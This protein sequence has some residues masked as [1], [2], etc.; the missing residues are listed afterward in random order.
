MVKSEFDYYFKSPGPSGGM[1]YD[2]KSIIRT[3]V[4]AYQFN[5]LSKGKM[6]L[7]LVGNDIIIRT[8][9]DS[10]FQ[11]NTNGAFQN[12]MVRSTV[13]RDDLLSKGYK[14]T[15][16]IPDMAFLFK[17]EEI[18]EIKNTV[19]LSFR[20]LKN[21]KYTD[22]LLVYLQYCIDKFTKEGLEII[23]FHQVES[24]KAFNKFLYESLSGKTSIIE[25]CIKYNEIGKVYKD[26]K[27]AI[28][29]RLHVFLLG[30]RHEA[31]PL[32][33]LN[34]DAK[35]SKISNIVKTF[36]LNENL[37]NIESINLDE[38]KIRIQ[39]RKI[40]ENQSLDCINKISNLF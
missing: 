12:Y 4:L 20:D 35:T 21:Q 10:W 36:D 8:K 40:N 14:N 32:A 16:F 23:F 31:I 11:K 3:V 34:S 28:S 18:S 26:A 5:Y 9:L 6:K 38:E 29:N 15:S 7:N 30:M 27:Y 24:D 19:L 2:Y 25:D 33:Y 1:G 39:I 22:E 13:N 37:I 17:P